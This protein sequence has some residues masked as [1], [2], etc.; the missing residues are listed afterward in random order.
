MTKLA[1]LISPRAEAAYFCDTEKVA[2]SE[3]AG[4][5]PTVKAAVQAVGDMRFV[6][7]ETEDSATASLLRLSW[8]QGVFRMGGDAMIPVAQTSDFRLHPDFVWG[9]KYRGKTNET[10]TQLLINT[11]L[12]QMPDRAPEDLSLL[13]PMSGRGTTLLWA[14]RY[15]MRATGVEQDGTVLQDLQRGLKKW[16]KLHRQK[17]KLRDGW[18]QKSNRQGI[19]KFLE[20]A[21]EDASMKVIIGDSAKS[22]ELTQRKRFDLIVTDIPY[23]VQHMGGQK[24]RNPLQTLQDCAPVWS[25]CLA[26]GGTMVIA[27]NAN[28]PKRADLIAAF[29]GLG[30]DVIETDLSH[31]MSESIL[32][33]VLVLKHSA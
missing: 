17:H 18:V 2:L 7:V 33:D 23:G 8:V 3:L 4:L 32:R 28:I 14:M 24:S 6:L 13:D 30:L 16:T 10:L 11:G 12:Q 25:N 21:A 31:R 27:F 1:L 9:E 22:H 19:G 5:L 26:P 29:D 15:G 20:F